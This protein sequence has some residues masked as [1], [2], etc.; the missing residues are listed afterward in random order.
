M[1]EMQLATH[2]GSDDRCGLDLSHG[3]DSARGAH[4]VFGE[5]LSWLG[6]GVGV[7]LPVQLS[8]VL[9]PM[10]CEVLHQVYDIYGAEEVHMLVADAWRVEAMVWFRVSC[11]VER[12]QVA[13]HGR[14]IYDGGC[15]L[16]VQ[17][18]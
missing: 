3:G 1:K 11:G 10:T 4:Q 14:N 15:L 6:G 7:V 12:A 9:Y 13:T 5:M 8:H 18:A 16:D 2:G 17:H